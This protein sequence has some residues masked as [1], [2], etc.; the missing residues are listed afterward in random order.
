MRLRS[1]A[2][3]PG[4]KKENKAEEWGCV[5]FHARLALAYFGRLADEREK[6]WPQSKT[7]SWQGRSIK[8]HIA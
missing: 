7:F 8:T 4:G 1:E 6:V 2:G 5:K 3:R